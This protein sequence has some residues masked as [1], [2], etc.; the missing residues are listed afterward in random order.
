MASWDIYANPGG[1]AVE[2]S[3]HQ[4]PEG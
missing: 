2:V 1:F 3:Y 4:P